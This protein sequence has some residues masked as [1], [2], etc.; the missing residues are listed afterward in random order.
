MGVVFFLLLSGVI[1]VLL[2]GFIGIV[3]FG[4]GAVALGIGGG[5]AAANMK[6][7]QAKALLGRL[8][9]IAVLLGVAFLLL[10]KF[11]SMI[12]LVIFLL[13]G[14]GILLI[15]LN[16]KKLAGQLEHKVG[17]IVGIIAFFLGIFTGVF[18]MLSAGILLALGMQ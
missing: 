4:I 9:V 3:L 6:N 15:S 2:I 16:G 14:I 11:M 17:R 1:P 8:C 18:M 12:G 7:G 13:A 5:I 10:L